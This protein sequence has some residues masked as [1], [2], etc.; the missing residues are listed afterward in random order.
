TG[1]FI[2]AAWMFI[3][4]GYSGLTTM[5]VSYGA[6]FGILWKLLGVSYLLVAA[7][8]LYGAHAI[9]YE[10]P[11]RVATFVRVYLGAVIFYLV[12]NIVFIIA[13][14]IAVA[15]AVA[16]AKKTCEDAQSS[17]PANERTDC[18]VNTVAYPIVGWLLPFG[19]GVVWQFW[20]L[21]MEVGE[22][23]RQT[24]EQHQRKKLSKDFFGPGAKPGT[25]PTDVEQ[26][27]GLERLE[28]LAAMEGKEFFEMKPLHITR[29]GTKDDPVLV[30][31][32][33]PIRYVG[34][35]GYPTDSHEL[36]WITVDK[37]HG[38]DRCPECGQVFKLNFVGKED[39]GH[40]HHH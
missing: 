25:I 20:D 12:A 1:A 3:W 30:K 17:L 11:H 24:D 2:V 8:A 32:V 37:S 33:D 39:H 18:N 14:E 15:S 7:G 6:S 23:S 35:S 22:N 21:V 31:S 10:I 27:T 28:L 16:A 36:L 9:F 34:C 19:F 40:G 4:M 29:K 5:F 38:I 13:V 26:A